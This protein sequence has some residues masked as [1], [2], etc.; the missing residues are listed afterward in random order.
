[1]SRRILLATIALVVAALFWWDL[2][3]GRNC[4]PSGGVLTYIGPARTWTC[5]HDGR[6]DVAPFGSMPDTRR[7]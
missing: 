1:M 5:S 4:E 6:I 2:S 3:L 7:R